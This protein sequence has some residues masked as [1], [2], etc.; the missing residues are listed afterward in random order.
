MDNCIFCKIVKGEIPST[1]VFEDENTLAFYDISPKAPV[2]VIVIPKK[3]VANII[4][5]AEDKE[6]ISSVINAIGKVAKITG[7]ESDGFRCV[8][9]TGHDGGQSVDHFHFHVLA[10]VTFGEN[11]G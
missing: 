1:K 3:H 2:H 6:L 7:V 8:A 10:G 5:A 11:F 9:N 4:E